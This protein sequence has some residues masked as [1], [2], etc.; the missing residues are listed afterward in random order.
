MNREGIPADAHAPFQ[1][2]QELPLGL[3]VG[4]NQPQQDRIGDEMSTVIAA[5]D[6]DTTEGWPS[7]RAGEPV[8]C[9]AITLA[10]A[11]EMAK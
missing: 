3:P 11:D 6:G 2:S 4:V 1:E 9:A 5:D 7:G 8:Y 10:N